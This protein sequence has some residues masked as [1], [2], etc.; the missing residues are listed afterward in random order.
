MVT[1]SRLAASAARAARRRA[2]LVGGEAV[3]IGAARRGHR[4]VDQ[5]RAEGRIVLLD[6]GLDNVAVGHDPAVRMDDGAAA[7]PGRGGRA[8]GDARP[9]PTVDVA[10]GGGVDT[11]QHDRGLGPEHRR[12]EL[13]L[14]RP[15]VPVPEQ[16]R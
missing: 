2:L 7:D 4:L 10:A 16:P 1:A 15:S 11:D 9:A 14:R 6:E 8:G 5:L 12:L 3:E 13:R